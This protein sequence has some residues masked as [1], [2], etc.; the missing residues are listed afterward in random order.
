[1]PP[2]HHGPSR[3]PL[4]HFGWLFLLAGLG[5]AAATVLIPAEDDLR[6]A[7]WQRDRALALEAR[8]RERMH[9]YR[10]ALEAVDQRDPLMMERLAALY[11][12]ERHP[13]AAVLLHE[14][15][16]DN[17]PFRGLEPPP[18]AEP[19]LVYTDSMLARWSRD[20]RTR[21]WLIAGAALSILIGLL[22]AGPV[23]EPRRRRRRPERPIDDAE[24]TAA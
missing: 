22:P 12:D 4:I 19:T 10:M 11:R 21:L 6:E 7:A 20:E 15:V 18:P 5:I 17:S 2:A 24:P 16:A 8:S 13:D 9:R 3:S 14:A 23:R 1:M